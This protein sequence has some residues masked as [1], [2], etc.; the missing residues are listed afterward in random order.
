MKLAVCLIFLLGAG[1]VSHAHNSVVVLVIKCLLLTA[2]QIILQMIQ[3]LIY[4]I[5]YLT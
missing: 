3:I 5:K 2:I 1:V 4:S